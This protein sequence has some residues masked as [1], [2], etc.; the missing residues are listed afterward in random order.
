MLSSLPY[1]QCVADNGM[2]SPADRVH[3]VDA[4]F[5]DMVKPPTVIDIVIATIVVVVTA[6]T[7]MS[8]IASAAGRLVF[9][10]RHDR[11]GG[12]QRDAR[13]IQ[14]RLGDAESLPSRRSNRLCY[15]IVSGRHCRTELGI[16]IPSR[17]GEHTSYE[18]Q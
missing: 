12:I 14:N 11:L 6:T 10:C 4:A 16:G 5:A 17:I 3:D 7:S 18:N 15:E 9:S 13:A 8:S 2:Y 1:V